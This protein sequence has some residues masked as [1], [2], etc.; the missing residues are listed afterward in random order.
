MKESEVPQ[1]PAPK[2]EKLPYQ[3]LMRSQE[4]RARGLTPEKNERVWNWVDRRRANLPKMTVKES[5]LPKA[6]FTRNYGVNTVSSEKLLQWKEVNVEVP[7]VEESSVKKYTDPDGR[8]RSVFIHNNKDEKTVYEITGGDLNHPEMY[9]VIGADVQKIAPDG[10]IIS[11]LYYAGLQSKLTPQEFR[12]EGKQYKMET[13]GLVFMVHEEQSDKHP[14]GRVALT[15]HQE[16]FGTT[17]HDDHAF[18]RTPGQG[19]SK[20][21]EDPRH[22]ISIIVNELGGNS[23]LKDVRVEKY[24]LKPHQKMDPDRLKNQDNVTFTGV[25]VTPEQANKIE[26]DSQDKIRFFDHEEFKLL[27]GARLVNSHTIVAFNEYTAQE[28]MDKLQEDRDRQKSV[29]RKFRYAVRKTVS[30]SKKKQ[31]IIHNS[32]NT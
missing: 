22:P 32:S 6:K 10:N 23:F 21:L 18:L 19:S 7:Q 8:E 15:L 13:S 11:D 5:P 2:I 16:P 27:T 28:Y 9:K 1:P 3:I 25:T 20:A 14:K 17:G 29:K 12:I 31:K 30:H 24:P 26:K 4:E